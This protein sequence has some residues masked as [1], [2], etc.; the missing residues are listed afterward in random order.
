MKE[1]ERFHRFLSEL[2][3]INVEICLKL[4]ASHE[5]LR[6]HI[7]RVY[8]AHQQLERMRRES[9]YRFGKR[10]N[11]SAKVAHLVLMRLIDQTLREAENY[12]LLAE[13]FP[14]DPQ[15]TVACLERIKRRTVTI[16]ENI[17]ELFETELL[18]RRRSA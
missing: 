4:P 16:L 3:A 8:L 10:S 15:G 18:S 14:L 17:D 1:Q 2:Q 11:P 5:S 9:L 6:R 13:E 12:R 7:R